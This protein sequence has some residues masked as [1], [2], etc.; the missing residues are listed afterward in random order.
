MKKVN[1]RELRSLI[2]STLMNEFLGDIAKA[3]MDIAKQGAEVGLDATK[4]VLKIP[5]TESFEKDKLKDETRK[6]VKDAIKPILIQGQEFKMPT[7]IVKEGLSRGSLY[8]R[9]Y[10]GRY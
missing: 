3:G 4:E 1:R 5:G 10:Y 8:R 2:E 9:R 7:G 6:A